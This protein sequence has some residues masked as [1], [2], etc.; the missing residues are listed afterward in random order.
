MTDAPAN[1]PRLT[2]NVPLYKDP[3]PL[4]KNDHRSLGLKSIEKPYE[5]VR[6]TH[7]VPTVVG[8]FGLGSAYYP[9]IFIGDRKMPA[10]VMGLQKGQNL[11]IT[12]DGQFDNEFMVP[13]FI[14]RYPF[15]SASNGPDQPA[16]FCFDR[17][18]AVISDKPDFP[19][20]D[21]TGEP[22]S[23]TQEAIDFV[24][25]F[26]SDS[27]VTER[28]VARLIELDLFEKKEVKVADPNDRSK[29]IKVADYYGVSEEKLLALPDDVFL[30][31][32]KDGLLG[33][34]YAHML[35]LSRWERIL[36]RYFRAVGQAQAAKP[37][38]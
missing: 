33:P 18:A 25:A 20:F 6:E 21:E 36:N 1:G 5:F 37:A 12:E 2:G 16:T 26:E 19:F 31:A 24:S 10:L 4:N 17:A 11:F 32:K 15:V 14:R 27:R 28:F 30:A 35:S 29:S 3:V 38:N 8:E 22:T 7:F 13:A 23:V 9:I 34:I